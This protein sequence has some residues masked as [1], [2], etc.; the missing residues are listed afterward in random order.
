MSKVQ[1]KT[2]SAEE[3]FVFKKRKADS[4]FLDDSFD[5]ESSSKKIKCDE[6]VEKMPAPEEVSPDVVAE[7]PLLDP[8]QVVKVQVEKEW[9]L[10]IISVCGNA[11]D[12]E[13]IELIDLTSNDG[14]S[15]S[16]CEKSPELIDLMNSAQGVA[17]KKVGGQVV[18]E[19]GDCAAGASTEKPKVI[20]LTFQQ[21]Q[22]KKSK[23]ED[24]SGAYEPGQVID[25]TASGADVSADQAEGAENPNGMFSPC[26]PS[27]SSENFLPDLDEV[28]QNQLMDREA[29][30]EYDRV[31]YGEFT[32]NQLEIHVAKEVNGM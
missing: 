10:R 16:L 9:K 4:F 29:A 17:E 26:S 3:S 14:Q 22:F 31:F 25:L 32:R 18:Q 13:Q 24:E 30:A 27:V 8:H 15:K 20:D 21:E 6:C 19:D 12:T 11:G 23:E 28:P 5:D 1:K 2:D 7:T